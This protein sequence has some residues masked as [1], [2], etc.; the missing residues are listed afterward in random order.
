M[1]LIVRLFLFSNL[2]I[3]LRSF[4]DKSLLSVH[5]DSAMIFFLPPIKNK[6]AVFP[7]IAIFRI[8]LDFFMFENSVIGKFN[9]NWKLHLKRAVV[10]KLIHIPTLDIIIEYAII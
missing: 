1:S 10:E 7:I 9:R 8:K 3:F 2:S 5:F 6:F 4:S